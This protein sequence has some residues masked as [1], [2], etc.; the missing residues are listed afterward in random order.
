[1]GV[2]VTP[3]NGANYTWQTA[4]GWNDPKSSV[5]WATSYPVSYDQQVT[6]TVAAAETLGNGV[7]KPLSEAFAVS[8]SSNRSYGLNKAESVAVSELPTRAIKKAINEV[9]ATSESITRNYGLNKAESV[10]VSES[11]GHTFQQFIAEALQALDALNNI[12]VGNIYDLPFGESVA[13]SD[14][15]SVNVAKAIAEAIKALD[16][17]PTSAFTKSLSE[18]VVVSDA[19]SA[20]VTKNTSEALVVTDAIAH[21]LSKSILEA[22]AV[23]E[24]F[25]NVAQYHLNVIETV[26]FVEA[27][28]GNY[29]KKLAESLSIAEARSGKITKNVSE[30]IAV[31][32]SFGRVVQFYRNIAEALGCSDKIGSVLPPHDAS[33]SF[34]VED[35]L[36]H[37]IEHRPMETLSFAELLEK[38]HSQALN[39]TLT[40]KDSEKKTYTMKVSEALNLIETYMRKANA[41]F[42][43]MVVSEGD[44][45]QRTFMN[46]VDSGAVVGYEPFHDFIP[47]DYSYQKALFRVILESVNSDR[48]RLNQLS[49]TVDVP[50]V[51]DRGQ[52]VI[53]A[54]HAAAGVAVTFGRQFHMVPEVTLTLKGG[55]VLAIPDVLNPTSTGFTAKLKDPTTGNGVAGT[56][57]WAAHGY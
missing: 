49:V 34:S 4:W 21:S 52:V 35:A 13:I 26:A 5:A 56:L 28:G 19:A 25:S 10:V 46:A 44:M 31:A 16:A 30:L 1:M 2:T 33:E 18:A 23:I 53:D 51:F 54:A 7:T 57:T 17:L 6:E 55:T 43:N 39:E 3:T 38:N 32:E 50:D 14:G 15:H 24:M 11:I 36:T 29:S 48:A 12:I 47:G 27:L 37:L 9:F 22:I 20:G 40:I 45:D 8:E 42:S 41:V